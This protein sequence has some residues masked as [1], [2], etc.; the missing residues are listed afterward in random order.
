MT[1]ERERMARSPNTLES[2]GLDAELLARR[3]G[4]PACVAEPVHPDVEAVYFRGALSPEE[5]A[6]MARALD[7]RDGWKSK[8]AKKA[9]RD[10]E[11]VP[12]PSEELAAARAA[13]PAA[14]AAGG[15]ARARRA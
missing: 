4:A 10:A 3:A 9:V 8:C 11:G 7:A 1:E 5:C 14:L 15:V 13:R 12:V 2:F 6:Q